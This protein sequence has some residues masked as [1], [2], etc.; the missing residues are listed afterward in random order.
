MPTFRAW[1]L[2]GALARTVG[3]GL[4]GILR[5]LLCCAIANEL[6]ASLQVLLASPVGQ[7]PVMTDAHKSLWKAMQQE[8][9]DKLNFGQT[10]QALAVSP[11]VVFVAEGY[12][13]SIQ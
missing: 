8:P 6:A 10:H 3:V 12:L 7:Q 1:P 9:T 5:R 2:Q 4:C 13:S 11:P